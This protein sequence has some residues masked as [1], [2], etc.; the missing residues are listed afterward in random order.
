MRLTDSSDS[1]R[2]TPGMGRLGEC[3]G[4]WE[5][6]WMSTMRA[7]GSRTDSVVVVVVVAVAATEDDDDDDDD[8]DDASGTSPP[9]AAI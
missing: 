8:D 4:G 1:L 6:R 5:V 2:L 3:G 9:P 7:A